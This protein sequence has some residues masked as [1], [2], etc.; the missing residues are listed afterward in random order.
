M[1]PQ[2]PPRPPAP[3][4]G[5]PPGPPQGMP[6]PPMLHDLKIKKVIRNGKPVIAAVPP[7]EFLIDTDATSTADARFLCHWSQVTRA[8]LVR[9]GFD[10]EKVENLPRGSEL[11]FEPEVTSR[12]QNIFNFGQSVRHDSAM[13]LIDRY[14]CYVQI[15]ADDDGMAEW[16]QVIMAGGMSSEH[17][18][19][20]EPW[21]D[22]VPFAVLKPYDIPHR[23]MG[24]SVADDVIDI[25]QIKTVLL[26][27]M[28]DNLYLSNNPIRG[29]DSRAVKNPDQ[30]VN[31][32]FG[33]LVETIGPPGAAIQDFPVPN[34]AAQA[35]QA[36]E[37]LDSIIERRT[38]ISRATMALDPDALQNE[39]A[40]SAQLRSDASMSK[41]ELVARNFAEGGFSDLYC[42][43]LRLVVKHQDRVRV[44]RLRDK[45]VDVDPRDWNVDM[46][47]TI[48]TGLGA[49]SKDRDMAMLAQIMGI[50]EKIV[51]QLGPDNP[52]VTPDRLWNTWDQMVQAAGLKNTEQYFKRL[53]PE[54][55]KAAM[56]AKQGKPDPK[57]QAAQ[58]AMQAKLELQKQESQQR[59]Q[60][61][62]QKM[63]ADGQAAQ[64]KARFE[65]QYA[66]AQLQQALQLAQ[67][68][69][70]AETQLAEVKA[71]HDAQAG[72]AAAQA[73][74][75]TDLQIAQAKMQIDRD[76]RIQELTFERDV[77]MA[78]IQSGIQHV[79]AQL[80]RPQ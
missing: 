38:G 55:A 7:E 17:I 64:A 49:G 61:D 75:Q 77:R 79:S 80:P 69:L 73:K 18:L 43:M 35:F 5:P 53:S 13:E 21:G 22:P 50:Q 34:V 74:A 68:K 71:Q 67:A 3:M 48:N 33:E 11:Q 65:M 6:P 66:E 4:Q 24:R 9:Q 19:S 26:R 62:Q 56:E 58:Q 39:T 46:D 37:Y 15:D 51:T 20:I 12:N 25:Q 30:L 28:L 54:E 57:Q 16:L 23:F 32:S 36:L 41:V 44:I 29:F 31:P 14:E 52:V 60:M 27:Q 8:E 42:G 70:Q 10:R 47:V 1:P 63:E 40:T 78:Q 76:L 2:G 72:A 59:L 45:W